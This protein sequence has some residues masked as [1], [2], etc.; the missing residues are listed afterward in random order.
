MPSF[1]TLIRHK[2]ENEILNFLAT[3]EIVMV[4]F[5]SKIFSTLFTVSELDTTVVRPG[6]LLKFTLLKSFYFD[7]YLQTVDLG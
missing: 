4:G 5:F 7:M 1:W 3:A 2:V 6:F